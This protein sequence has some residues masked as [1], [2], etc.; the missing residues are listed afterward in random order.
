M[1]AAVERVV[2]PHQVN[3]DRAASGIALGGAHSNTSVAGRSQAAKSQNHP[4]ACSRDV[5]SS[6][7]RG[8]VFR[9]RC[10]S[11]PRI[12]DVPSGLLRQP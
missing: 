8:L 1:V 2:C 7:L 6:A 4:I 5:R 9:F 3:G 10:P 12:V 11:W